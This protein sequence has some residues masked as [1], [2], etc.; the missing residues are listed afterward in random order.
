VTGGGTEQLLFG[1]DTTTASLT[2]AQLNQI[3]FY[4]D[5]G[6]TFLGTGA[7]ATVNDGEVVPVP[8]PSTWVIGALAL[9][10][11]GFTQ[12]RRIRGLIARRA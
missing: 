9:A 7:W 2:Q 4:S 1:T 5:S 6:T 10:A 12:R 11:I 3:S 8:E